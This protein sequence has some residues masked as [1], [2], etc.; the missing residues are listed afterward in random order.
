MKK[1][2]SKLAKAKELKDEMM[3][4]IDEMMKISQSEVKIIKEVDTI[5]SIRADSSLYDFDICYQ[6]SSS[7]QTF[8]N[9][10]VDENGVQCMLEEVL[11]IAATEAVC[12]RYFR[13]CSTI[14]KKPYITSMNAE[15]VNDMV[16]VRYYK[17]PLCKLIQ[18][19]EMF[20]SLSS[21]LN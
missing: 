14:V 19:K 1:G 3:K 11:S 8:Q 10:Y 9:R 13:I 5:T 12:E 16:F 7:T 4:V 20:S 2:E 21:V 18:G 15:T 17:I 6:L